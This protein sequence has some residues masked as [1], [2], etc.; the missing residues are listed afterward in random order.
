MIMEIL[1][2]FMISIILLSFISII[3]LIFKVPKSKSYHYFI[4]SSI[5]SIL[6]SFISLTGEPSNFYMSR[7]IALLMFLLILISNILY[8]KYSKKFL[9]S[10]LLSLSII[11]SLL[12][13]IF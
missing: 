9:A 11:I 12:I 7:A 2:M 5:F 8:F 3:V 6:L 13:L 10:I 1:A 4:F